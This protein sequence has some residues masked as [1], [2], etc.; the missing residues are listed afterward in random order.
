MGVPWV[1]VWIIDIYFHAFSLFKPFFHFFFHFFHFS[2]ICHGDNICHMSLRAF[3]Y[4]PPPQARV[5]QQRQP[6]Q[7]RQLPQRRLG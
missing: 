6:P 3:R 2:D 1:G 7:Q 4:Q 5:Q